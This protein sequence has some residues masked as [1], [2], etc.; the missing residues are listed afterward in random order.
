ML[1]TVAICTFNRA[2]SLRRTLEFLAMMPPPSDVTWELVI[3]N[4]NCSDHTDEVISGYCDRLPVRRLFE[5][6]SGHSNARNCAINAAQGEYIVWT[7]DDVVVDPGWLTAYADAFRRWPEAAVFGGRILPR[8]ESPVPKWIAE[9]MS[10]LGGPY[11][12]REFGQD[13]QQLSVAEDRLPF[14]A[15]FRDPR[16]RTAGLSV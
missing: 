6:R 16:E 7:D 13:V 12:I 14:G 8:L 11:A 10:V 2:K 3:V 15:E 9:S 1:I 5:Q 4:N